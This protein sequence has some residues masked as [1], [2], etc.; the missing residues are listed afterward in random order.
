M[1]T[2]QQ[3]LVHFITNTWD[4]H[5]HCCARDMDARV[6]GSGSRQLAG[7]DRLGF[8]IGKPSD[9]CRKTAKVHMIHG[10]AAG[11]ASGGT[12][13]SLMGAVFDEKPENLKLAADPYSMNPPGAHRWGAATCLPITQVHWGVPSLSLGRTVLCSPCPDCRKYGSARSDVL[14]GRLHFT[15]VSGHS[16]VKVV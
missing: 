9:A 16:Q 3:C 5:S 13:A 1:L 14:V 8:M 10:K 12:I 11:G 6:V 7:V 4:E 2:I 15:A